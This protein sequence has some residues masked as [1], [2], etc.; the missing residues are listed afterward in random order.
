MNKYWGIF[1]ILVFLASCKEDNTNTSLE[2]SVATL[3]VIEEPEIVERYGFNLNDFTVQQD[4]VR[5]GDS[6][7][8]LM[9]E[10][11]V[12]YPKI[13]KISQDFRD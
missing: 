2:N 9:L 1:M 5:N 10:H 12:E 7:G 6:F 11:K 3:A 13:Y 8:E 4:T